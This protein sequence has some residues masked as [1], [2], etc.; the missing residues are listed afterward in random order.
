MDIEVEMLEPAQ[1][2]FYKE[3]Y[4]SIKIEN[5]HKTVIK[6]FYN[7]GEE[8]FIADYFMKYGDHVVSVKPESLKQIIQAR[9]ENLLHHYHKL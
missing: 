3:H 2:L 6:G 5:G 7:P 9:V 4:P 8:K 1:D